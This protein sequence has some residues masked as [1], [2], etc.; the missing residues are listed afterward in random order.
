MIKKLLT[1]IAMFSA[2]HAAHAQEPI[3]I[4][5]LLVD[6][7]PYAAFMRFQTEPA[8]LA[9]D[10]LNAAGGALGRK[11]ELVPQ[12]YNGTPAGATAAVARL[13][14]QQG[15]TLITGFTSSG[16]TLAIA[17]RLEGLNALL[18]DGIAGADEITGKNCQRNL[19][20]TAVNDTMN[21]NA[22]RASV[23][24]SGARTWNL[25]MADTTVGHDYARQFTSLVQESGG[26]VQ[27]TLFAPLGTT[28][29]GSLISQLSEKPAD[30]LVVTVTGAAAIAL[31]KQQQQFGLFAKYKTL[32]SSYFTND[33]WLAAQG[34][35]TVGVVSSQSYAWEMPGA[36]NA[37]FVAAFEA[38]FKRK[39]TFADADTFTNF[40]LVHAAIIKAKSTEA[41][42]VRSALSGLK[43]A[44]V[45]G[46]VEMRAADNQLLRPIAIVKVGRDSASKPAIQL[47]SVVPAANVV[48]AP[49]GDCK[50]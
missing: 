42:P 10:T 34:D 45:L 47:Q 30:G 39:P 21:M 27:T 23:K 50:F 13:A 38:R 29:F 8:S 28:D 2:L 17:S 36:E 44:T 4:G 7:G 11:Y 41:V 1:F 22:L 31:A 19:F 12:G 25:L 24:N 40:Q 6:A 18:I 33:L 9:V 3:K 16:N 48:G 15:V 35:A 43:A 5:M 37:A 46:A 14:Q 49:S 32:L 26:V 20:R